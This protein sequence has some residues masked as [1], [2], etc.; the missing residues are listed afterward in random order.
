MSKSEREEVITGLVSCQT[1][2]W[3]GADPIQAARLFSAMLEDLVMDAALQSHHE[4]AR[5]RAPCQICR[6]R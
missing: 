6:T 3:L 4:I 1:P 5:S 2:Q